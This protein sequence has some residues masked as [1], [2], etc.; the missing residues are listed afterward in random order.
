MGQ[1]VSGHGLKTVGGIGAGGKAGTLPL[2]SSGAGTRAGS[3]NKF[4]D[5]SAWPPQLEEGKQGKHIEGHN[6][7][8]PGRS[9]LTIT[10]KEAADLVEKYAGTGDVVGN[11]STSNKE[12]VDFKRIIGSAKDANGNVIPTTMGIIH[13][14]HK[15]THIVPSKP[16][17]K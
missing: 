3:S 9:K 12:R 2:D 13:H 15:G 1:G 4:S 6:N 8:V 14:S 16:Q 17:E 5:H 11:V 10:M 7:F